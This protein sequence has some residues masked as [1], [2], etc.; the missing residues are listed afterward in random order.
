MTCEK[1]KDKRAAN[2]D[3]EYTF[4]CW[5][6]VQQLQEKQ[7]DS[8][9]LVNAPISVGIFPNNVLTLRSNITKKGEKGKDGSMRLLSFIIEAQIE[10]RTHT[11]V[12]QEAYFSWNCS[13]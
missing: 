12:C 1:K 5:L 13:S 6:M 9:R 2:C 8:L 4:F 3:I 11:Q 10:F 7:N